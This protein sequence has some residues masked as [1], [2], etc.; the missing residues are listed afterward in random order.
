MKIKT[1]M[2]CSIAAT[3]FRVS[4]LLAAMTTAHAAEPVV[5]QGDVSRLPVKEITVFKDGH[6]F[7]LHEG[8][9]PA[10]ADGKVVLENLPN[11]VIGTFWPYSADAKRPLLSVVSSRRKV[12]VERTPLTL[13]EMLEANVGA[14]VTIMVGTNPMTGRIVN[15]PKRSSEELARTSPP[16]TEEVVTQPGNLFYFQTFDS[17]KI[18]DFN[19]VTDV[20][21]K[22]VPKG[23]VG[24]E[25][26]RN[27]LT[28]KLDGAGA[29]AEAN[30]GMVYLQK[31]IRWIPNYK[32]TLDGKG[33]AVIKLQ[34]TLINELTDLEGVTANLVI[35]VP[36][37]AFK[38][39][40]D[41]IALSQVAAQLSRY[42]R[43]DAQTA[44]AFNNGIM[45]QSTRMGEYSRPVRVDTSPTAKDLGPDVGGS[46]AA[47]D[48]FVFTVKNISLKKGERMVVAVAEHKVKY[49]DVY[50]LE[51]P[52]AP[53]QEVRRQFSASQQLELAKLLGQP[54][55]MH[56]IRL[57]NSN[58]FPLTTAP[59]LVMLEGRL[60]A[61]SLM[62]YTAPGASSDLSITTAV[63][64]EA[65]RHEKAAR[66]MTNVV[67][68]PTPSSNNRPI[69]YDSLSMTGNVCVINFKK[70]A[71]D[72]EIT[73]HVVGNLDKADH[74]GVIS[75]A[76][77]ADE[78][79]L[80][81]AGNY[82]AWW[83][84][85]SWQDWWYHFNGMGRVDWK[86]TLKPGEKI[87]LGYNWHYFWP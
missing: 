80:F 15:I 62:T 17:L 72:V 69:W 11:P 22:E 47:E 54:K 6:S 43:E 50:T 84:W 67:Q 40:P 13:R 35:G 70:E 77:L 52:F 3:G 7:V 27:L 57:L 28:L 24:A 56:K 30:V 86:L 87:E 14:E 66:R 39:T 58:P 48:L 78:R 18:V 25:E 55:V 85:Y 26:F 1:F 33:N 12:R 10:G 76:N 2:N 61:Q 29:A 46:G 59:T 9:L 75:Q 83:S 36:T 82:P 64:V 37:F 65:R 21:F 71:V 51:L 44:N 73:R 81:S 79:T 4:A 32:V 8:R 31:G 53:P 23:M 42:F 60:L 16:D 63:E 45:S 19:R 34:G 5:S 41:P 20:T 68:W 38:D 74:D 49:K